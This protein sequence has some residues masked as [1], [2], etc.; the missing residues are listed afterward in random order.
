MHLKDQPLSNLRH[1][2]LPVLTSLSAV[3]PWWAGSGGQLLRFL[4]REFSM[5]SSNIL[6]SYR[7]LFIRRYRG[8]WNTVW[9]PRSPDH[10]KGFLSH[11]AITSSTS[12]FLLHAGGDALFSLLNLPS[13][14]HG[15]IIYI[16]P[17]SSNW[18]FVPN[19]VYRPP[20]NVLRFLWPRL[21]ENIFDHSVFASWTADFFF[22][23]PFC[24]APCSNSRR[25][26]FSH[27]GVPVS[28]YDLS[29]L[30]PIWIYIYIWQCFLQL[31]FNSVF[32]CRTS[33]P[34]SGSVP[35]RQASPVIFL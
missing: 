25:L 8:L 9:F 27:S 20:Y 32:I 33:N 19:P 7:R 23:I 5:V 21:R 12:L 10:Q 17:W 15:Q 18:I 6:R 2:Q 34:K 31:Y 4:Q 3:F 16:V 1:F 13:S 22:G 29:P 30:V 14:F 24:P 11:M 28:Q 35:S 26:R